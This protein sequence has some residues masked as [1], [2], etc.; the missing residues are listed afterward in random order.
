MMEKSLSSRDRMRQ[1]LS[2]P[3]E[4]DRVPCCFMIFSAL[5]AQCEDPFE[6]VERQLD[7]GLDAVVE[8][9]ASPSDV[10]SEHADL[11]GLPV[12]LDSRVTIREWREE[13][14][15]ERYPLLGK[16]YD[17]PEGTLTV[18]VRKTEDWPYGDHVP[19]LDDFLVPRSPKALITGPEDLSGLRYLLTP[20]SSEDIR[21]FREEA[22]KA[23]A[24]ADRHGLLVTGGWGVGLEAGAWLCGLE[25]LIL[26]A[27]DRPEF[28]EELTAMIAAWNRQRMEVLLDEGVDLFIR[29][30]WYE[31]TDFWSPALYRR[32]V[33]PSLRQEV[34]WAHQAGAKFGYIQ[35]S[36]TMPLLELLLEAEVDVLIGVDPVQGKGTDLRAMKERVGEKMCLWGG[37]NGFLTVEL[38]SETE[39]REAVYNAIRTLAPGGGFILSPVDNV[40]DPS[41]H[42]WRNVRTM[43][44]A[45]KEVGEYPNP[46]VER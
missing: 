19:F 27:M 26:Y 3:G 14:P 2:P 46:N 28:V 40:R 16:A 22:R 37:V 33:F 34:R 24:F 21:T 11:H 32:F 1:A 41:E 17:T 20:P 44:E 6:F 45:W 15:G 35:T 7:L 12:R 29:R 25:N 42:A 10:Q 4:P 13:R 43:I 8:L 18:V 9:P 36:G 30:G 38:G 5:K 39:V 23:K 31:G